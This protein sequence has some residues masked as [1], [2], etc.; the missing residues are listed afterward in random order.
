MN[1][2]TTQ[3]LDRE[4]MR[5]SL[6]AEIAVG[7]LPLPDI[8]KRFDMTSSQLKMLL[9]EPSFKA[10]IKQFK[11][12]WYE[13]ANSKERIRLKAAIMV[14]ENLLELHRIFN[15]I[16]LNPAARLDAFKQMTT[17]ADVQPKKDATDSGPKFNLTLNL[18]NESKPVTIDAV[19]AEEE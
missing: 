10:M 16:E 4:D 18:G 9:K 14:E 5:A 12:E 1:N 2:L 13:A 17:L 11:Q 6:A 15:D 19:A 3:P 8:L 7:L